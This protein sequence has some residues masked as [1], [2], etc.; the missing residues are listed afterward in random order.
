MAKADRQQ[1]Q[2]DLAVERV[3]PHAYDAERAVLSGVLADPTENCDWYHQVSDLGEWAFYDPRHKHVWRAIKAVMEHAQRPD[4]VEVKDRLERL[5]TLEK[6]GGIQYL[7]GILDHFHGGRASMAGW[8]ALLRSKAGMRGFIRRMSELVDD[9]Y[10]GVDADQEQVTPEMLT[11]RAMNVANE[12]SNGVMTETVQTFERLADEAILELQA[13]LEGQLVGIRTGLQAVDC[14]LR[15]GGLMKGQLVYIGARPSRGKTAL[16]VQI[17]EA[18]ALQGKRALFFSLEMPAREVM[19]RRLLAEA[20][21]DIQT[22][23]QWGDHHQRELALAAVGAAMARLY[24]RPFML[25]TNA[26]RNI[27]RLRAE[28]HREKARNGLDMVLVDYLGFVRGSKSSD[29]KSLYERVTEN[30]LA[31]HELAVELDVPVVVGV[32]L[33]RESAKQGRKRHGEEQEH[34]A[35]T[36]ADFRDSGSIEQDADIALLIHQASTPNALERGDAQLILAKQ[37]N[38]WTGSCPVFYEANYARFEDL[39]YAEQ[40]NLEA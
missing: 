40:Q 18:A 29:R 17:A 9:A 27:E 12:I 38:G 20:R 26:A 15:G 8:A 22:V 19:K 3:L 28:C 23:R 16:L 10:R 34:R 6:A 11:S 24:P 13:E 32:Q 21:V 36:L 37:R 33:N 2:S 1:Q 39:Q 31:L 14:K 35:P 30:S 4:L 7:A 25:T 5:G